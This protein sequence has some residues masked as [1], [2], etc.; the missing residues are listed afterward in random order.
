MIQGL[1]ELLEDI[2]QAKRIVLLEKMIKMATRFEVAQDLHIERRGEGRW[3]VLVFGGTVLDRDLNR[4]YEPMSSSRTEEF[5]S[6]TRF[7][8]EEAF[9]IAK[10]YDENETW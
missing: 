3:C 1:D 2:E 10:R 8:L 6:A 5:I 7:S 4:H 9:D